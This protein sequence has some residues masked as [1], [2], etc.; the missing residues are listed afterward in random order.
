MHSAHTV[1]RLFTVDEYHKM[2][3]AGILG[4]DDRVELIN[5]EIVEMSPIGSRHI[6]TV[7]RLTALFI[8]RLGD[9]VIVSVQNPVRLT[10]TSEPEPDV[11]LLRPHQ[12]YRHR[13]PFPE[14]VLLIVEVSDSSID[15]DRKVK[16]PL[17]A[18][19]G[20]QQVL[21]IDIEGEAVEEYTSPSQETYTTF[22]RLL[23]GAALEIVELQH[24][25]FTVNELLGG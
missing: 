14:D 25:E 6:D 11:T 7:N 24:T 17:Y 3:E 4:E 10:S 1:P 8:K 23:R 15:T 13:L 18:R 2:A 9:N 16:V 12:E 22:R 5:G 19:S 20:I 21:L